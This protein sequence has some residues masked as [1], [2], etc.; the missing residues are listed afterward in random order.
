MDKNWGV[1]DS[2]TPFGV[3]L[4]VNNDPIVSNVYSSF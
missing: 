2:F 1:N 4:Q 3:G